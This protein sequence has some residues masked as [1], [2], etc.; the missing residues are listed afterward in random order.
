MAYHFASPKELCNVLVW[1]ILQEHFVMNVL[2]DILAFLTVHV[3]IWIVQWPNSETVFFIHYSILFLAC[4]CNSVGS[5]NEVCN[6]ANGQCECKTNYA[7]RKCDECQNG[8]YSYPSCYSKLKIAFF[9]VSGLYHTVWKFAHFPAI[10]ILRKIFFFSFEWQK[11]IS[12]AK[13]K[14]QKNF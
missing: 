11:F 8:F 14:W 7:G 10:W 9:Y 13:S 1:K 2:R 4:D 12:R 3:R 6:R 5:L